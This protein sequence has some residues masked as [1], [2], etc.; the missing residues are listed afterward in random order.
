M[1]SS[2]GLTF[3]RAADPFV[4]EQIYRLNYK[5]FVE[6]IPQHE[7]NADRRLVDQFDA[8]NTYFV[9]L[10]GNT[11]IGMIAVRDRRP[12]SLDRK[13]ANL[14][15]YLPDARSICE[16]RLAAIE[17]DHR[18][19]MVFIGLA[20]CLMAHRDAKGYDLALIS[21]VEHRVPLY[22]R[23]GFVPFADPVGQA[24]ARFQPMYLTLDAFSNSA[25]L[26]KAR[27]RYTGG[28]S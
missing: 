25:L 10:D 11:V 17:Q 23:I 26:R 18:S 24:G 20:E 19:T 6:E 2:G 14:D 8:E 3:A 13:I 5:T 21:A 9:C 1:T 15:D 4:L 22:Q 16:F 12:F 7:P 28:R 27:Q